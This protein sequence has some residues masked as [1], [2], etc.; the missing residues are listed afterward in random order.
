MS[1]L[2]AGMRRDPARHLVQNLLSPLNNTF[3][4][5]VVPDTINPLF[6]SAGLEVFLNF[7]PLP[8]ESDA[9]DI[10]PDG[11]ITAFFQAD[12]YVDY[13]EFNFDVN[14]LWGTGFLQFICLKKV[15]AFG[16]T[17]CV[18]GFPIIMPKIG[19]IKFHID[20]KRFGLNRIPLAS[21]NPSFAATELHT[22]DLLD[23]DHRQLYT[24]LAILT[25]GPFQNPGGLIQ[26]VVNCVFTVVN[27]TLSHIPGLGLVLRWIS[28]FVQRTVNQI[29][30]GLRFVDAWNDFVAGKIQQAVANLIREFWDP[31]VKVK[32]GKITSRHLLASEVSIGQGRIQPAIYANFDSIVFDVNKDCASGPELRATVTVS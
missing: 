12:V 29:L 19:N 9:V 25:L 17:I 10:L 20:L 32:I 14:S 5:V 16:K 1:V 7:A 3:K 31:T 8:G 22:E 23:D 11:S 26:N 21:F 18:A 30:T 13:I 6:F 27:E 2:V 4:S 15:T 28:G 24:R